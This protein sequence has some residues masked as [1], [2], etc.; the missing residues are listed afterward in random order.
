MKFDL[1]KHYTMITIHYLQKEELMEIGLEVFNSDI[2][3]MKR[4]EKQSKCK[5]MYSFD[6][7]KDFKLLEGKRD[8]FILKRIIIL[9]CKQT[10][11]TKLLKRQKKKKS[12]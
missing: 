9:Q 10:E 1:K 6:H 11:E 4:K 2:V 12:N 8:T 5:S 7:P 3:I